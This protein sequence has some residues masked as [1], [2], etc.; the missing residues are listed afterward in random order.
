MRIELATFQTA[1]V[2]TLGSM[3]NT[4][5]STTQKGCSFLRMWWDP[6]MRKYILCDGKSGDVL[7]VESNNVVAARPKDATQFLQNIQNLQSELKQ[8]VKRMGRPPKN[9]SEPVRE[10]HTL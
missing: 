10:E 7:M 4:F 8:P 5:W 6:D 1:V 2:I 9:A 3:S